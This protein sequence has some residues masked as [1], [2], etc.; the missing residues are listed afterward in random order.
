MSDGTKAPEEVQRDLSVPIPFGPGGV[1]SV[2]GSTEENVNKA[3]VPSALVPAA[4]E[5]GV[6]TEWDATS[7]EEA[8]RWLTTRAEFLHKQSY[9]MTVIKEYVAGSPDSQGGAFG[10][11]DR[12]QS[13][14]IKHNGLYETMQRQLRSLRDRLENAAEALGKVKENYETA[15]GAN[16]MSAE[17][18]RQ[19]L[20]DA[21]S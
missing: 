17:Q 10:S 19:V 13:L 9:D 11:F 16:R 12:A 7:L 18:M 15:E 3:E 20:N 14:F 2:T 21:K 6:R 5:E 4:G 8:I 1:F